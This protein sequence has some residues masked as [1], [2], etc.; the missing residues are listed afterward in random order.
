MLQCKSNT[1]VTSTKC[2][3]LSHKEVGEGVSHEIVL[4]FWNFK[5]PPAVIMNIQKHWWYSAFELSFKF[6]DTSRNLLMGVPQWKYRQEFCKHQNISSK[7]DRKHQEQWKRGKN[8]IKTLLKRKQSYSLCRCH[9][10]FIQ[11][12]LLRLF[13]DTAFLDK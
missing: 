12:S 6:L 8:N 3:R 13:I 9:G 7:R 2:Y 1:G 11:K 4:K 5:S 10:I